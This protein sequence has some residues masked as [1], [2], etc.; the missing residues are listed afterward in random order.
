MVISSTKIE[1]VHKRQNNGK[2]VVGNQAKQ[3][4]IDQGRRKITRGTKEDVMRFAEVDDG[5]QELDFEEFLAMMPRL[6][7]KTHSTEEIRVWFDSADVDGSGLL[8]INEYFK[9]TLAMNATQHGSDALVVRASP[10]LSSLLL[11][12]NMPRFGHMHAGGL[13]EV[14]QRWNWIPR[15]QRM[16]IRMR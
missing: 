12:R 5:D 13:R 14:R 9:W 3:R 6:I 15:Q 7:R 10:R 16:G 4:A 11:P 8:S 1:E 2:V